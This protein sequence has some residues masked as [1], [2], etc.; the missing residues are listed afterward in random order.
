MDACNSGRVQVAWNCPPPGK[1]CRAAPLTLDQA[2]APKSRAMKI[3]P[4][5]GTSAAGASRRA[6]G[7][8][9]TGFSLP[10]DAPRAAT[11]ASAASAVASVDAVFAL[12]VDGAGRRHRQVRR[13]AAALDALDR[14]QA[15]LLDGGGDPAALAELTG[16][17]AD[18]EP[19]GDPGLDSA[20]NDIDVRAAVELA[21]RER[22][23]QGFGAGRA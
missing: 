14:L 11:A 8:G 1:D 22:S 3:E 19:T 15:A 21:K 4:T 7:A 9:A 12:Q 17:L 2:N 10:A 16:H 5:R 20:L 6:T 18:R 13:G 23:G